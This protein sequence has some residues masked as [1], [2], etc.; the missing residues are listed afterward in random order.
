MKK[1]G[2]TK[3][4]RN[5]RWKNNQEPYWENKDSEI[6]KVR[7]PENR[8]MRWMKY[9]RIP[10]LESG[11]PIGRL[12]VEFLRISHFFKKIIKGLLLNNLIWLLVKILIPL[13][14][15]IVVLF[16][17]IDSPSVPSNE[18][19][20]N[21]APT[22]TIVTVTPS[23]SATLFSS[24]E[25]KP[26][27][28]P[29]PPA[30]EASTGDN[31]SEPS[32]SETSTEVEPDQILEPP[33]PEASTGDNISEPSVSETSTEV[34]PDQILEPPAPEVSTGDNISEP[35]ISEASTEVKPDQILEP[36]A[37]EASTGDNISEP[38]I[39]E[40]S[41]EVKPD[42]ILE[43]PAPE[44]STGDNTLELSPILE[45]DRCG[46][47]YSYLTRAITLE[48]NAFALE[49]ASS[50]HKNCVEL[51]LASCKMVYDYLI[52]AIT[53]KNSAFALEYAKFLY[54]NC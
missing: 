14:T 54:S 2:K 5:K 42:Q 28:T 17:L 40:A 8:K 19:A 21:L 34:E 45:L 7:N 38:S 3:D 22:E 53:H 18:T 4:V 35:S 33:A 15:T 1:S 37:P 11:K 51:E 30:P 44:A 52:G 48:N 12:Q 43:P 31:V 24:A 47:V 20:N 9:D 10:D 6:H 49:Y 25:D 39:S 50:L 41:T 13:P 23:E 46:M 29:E 32:V 16:I 36:P 26:N 27:Q